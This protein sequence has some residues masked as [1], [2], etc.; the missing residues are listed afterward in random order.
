MKFTTN[1]IAEAVEAVRSSAGTEYTWRDLPF[2]DKFYAAYEKLSAAQKA[3]FEQC[4]KQAAQ[5]N[6]EI[7]ATSEELDE[8]HE[9]LERIFRRFL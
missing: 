5:E 3:D 7:P 2:S 8:Y 9:T 1:I 4:V 6:D